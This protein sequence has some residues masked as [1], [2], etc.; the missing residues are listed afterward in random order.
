MNKQMVNFGALK[1]I[2]ILIKRIATFAA[3]R[4]SFVEMVRQ[5]PILNC[6]LNQSLEHWQDWRL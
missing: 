4:E 2:G 5:Y 1:I 3:G 6:I